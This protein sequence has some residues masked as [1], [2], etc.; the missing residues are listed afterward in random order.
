MIEF[1]YNNSY[2]SRIQIALFEALYR[3]RYR[4]P[5]SWFEVGEVTAV[6]LYLVFD[7]LENVQLIRE[8]LR[9][10]QSQQKSYTDIRGKDLKFEV[11]DFVYLKISPIKGVKR[12]GR[13]GKLSA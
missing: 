2:H 12:L 13:K 8:K 3:R 6:G 10:S 7:Q 5:I 4:S 9:A 11:G 1:A